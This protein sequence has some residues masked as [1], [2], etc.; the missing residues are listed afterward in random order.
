MELNNLT[1]EQAMDY[2]TR[3]VELNEQ[4]IDL[5][6]EAGSEFFVYVSRR[7]IFMEK[8]AFYK[9]CEILNLPFRMYFRNDDRYK[10]QTNAEITIHGKRYELFCIFNLKGEEDDNV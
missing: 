5:Y 1:K 10:Y 7:D 9:V 6:A 8:D 4:F 2:L 3:Y